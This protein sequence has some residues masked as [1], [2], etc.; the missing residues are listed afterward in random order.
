MKALGLF[1]SWSILM[2]S[3]PPTI[4]LEI[5]VPWQQRIKIVRMLLLAGIKTIDIR[6]E[7]GSVKRGYY[8]P[9]TAIL[10][11]QKPCRE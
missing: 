1:A 4:D 10:S 6:S 8:N 5:R 7:G 2:P 3:E 11:F 9:E